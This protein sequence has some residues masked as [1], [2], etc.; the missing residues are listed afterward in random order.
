MIIVISYH[1]FLFKDEFAQLMS[2]M[3]F[4]ITW[5]IFSSCFGMRIHFPLQ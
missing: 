5:L 1:L 3:I 2:H 4:I